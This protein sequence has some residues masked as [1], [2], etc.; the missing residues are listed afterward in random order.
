MR[1]QTIL[2]K[3]SGLTV[4]ELPSPE[5]LYGQ[6]ASALLVLSQ[7]SVPLEAVAA[8][9][10]VSYLRVMRAFLSSTNS[11]RPNIASLFEQVAEHLTD[12]LQQSGR[13]VVNHADVSGLIRQMGCA[14]DWAHGQRP[15]TQ[16]T[17]TF[18]AHPK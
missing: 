14:Y 6:R 2:F 3:A 1:K 13:E 10:L 4:Q 15:L 5:Q 12:T 9:V 11:P 17:D 8:E 7:K 18:P 16:N